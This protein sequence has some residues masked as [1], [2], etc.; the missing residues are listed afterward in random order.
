MDLKRLLREEIDWFVAARSKAAK[1]DAELCRGCWTCHDVCP[2]GCFRPKWGQGV[3]EMVS[4]ERCVAC[5]ACVLQCSERALR[6][7]PLP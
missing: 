6:L 3:V 7:A 2:V 4:R 5:G 1:L